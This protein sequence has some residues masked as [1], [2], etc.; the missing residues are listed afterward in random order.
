MHIFVF[1]DYDSHHLYFPQLVFF[2]SF[3]LQ[4]ILLPVTALINWWTKWIFILHDFW[5][6]TAE[7][8]LIIVISNIFPQ[9]SKITNEYFTVRFY[10][11][12]TEPPPGDP[13]DPVTVAA[14]LLAIRSISKNIGVCTY[15][16]IVRTLF[17]IWTILTRHIHLI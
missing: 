4:N 15:S 13:V 10:F 12:A 7:K 6:D 1:D 2:L 9:F 11:S 3:S 5:F 17:S 14:T 8:K 16:I